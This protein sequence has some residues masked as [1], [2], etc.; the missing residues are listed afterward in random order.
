MF[1]PL[2]VL[3]IFFVR[4]LKDGQIEGAV[5]TQLN[6]GNGLH[7]REKRQVHLANKSLMLP[8]FSAMA[9]IRFKVV[10]SSGN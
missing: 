10:L 8:T 4:N 3:D 6:H 5:V 7:N 2:F 9:G 1:A